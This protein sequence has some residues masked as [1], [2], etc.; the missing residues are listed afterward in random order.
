MPHQLFDEN[1]NVVFKSPPI[2]LQIENTLLLDEEQRYQKGLLSHGTSI[3]LSGKSTYTKYTPNRVNRLG[4]GKMLATVKPFGFTPFSGY[5]IDP[6]R[7]YLDERAHHIKLQVRSS[8]GITLKS[9][10]QIIA[11]DIASPFD[12]ISMPNEPIKKQSGVYEKKESSP[13]QK[14]SPFELAEE[15]RISLSPEP[16]K[17]GKPFTKKI[18]P[19][20]GPPETPLAKKQGAPYLFT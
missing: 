11:Q 8:N 20:K 15:F 13:E 6:H 12:Y 3:A 16:T 14:S 17:P 18:V 4:L 1:F 10:H 9:R 2:P 5:Q 19:I 7:R